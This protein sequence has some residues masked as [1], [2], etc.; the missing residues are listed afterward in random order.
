MD[1]DNIKEIK[2]LLKEIEDNQYIQLR[3]SEHYI[4]CCVEDSTKDEIS[5]ACYFK[6]MKCVD[7]LKDLV[8]DY[9]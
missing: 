8:D 4:S 5:D 7:L 2:E 6:L 3:D 9:E 1:K